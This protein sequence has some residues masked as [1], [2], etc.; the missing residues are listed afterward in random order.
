[1]GRQRLHGHVRGL[2]ACCKRQRAADTVGPTRH[3]CS[4]PGWCCSRIASNSLRAVWLTTSTVAYRRPPGPGPRW[5]CD[6]TGVA[7]DHD[8]HFHRAEPSVI[9]QSGS[10]ARW[11][12]L[13]PPPATLLG[14]I[15]RTSDELALDLLH[16][17]PDRPSTSSPSSRS[18]CCS[19]AA[20]SIA[21]A[22][23]RRAWAR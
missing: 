10:G 4:S 6:R 9:A 11:V 19:R 18:G 1:M 8:E 12:E 16:Q 3:A 20:T 15:T 17:P 13:E 7:V 21:D 5:S 2:P 23:L 14:G 22:E